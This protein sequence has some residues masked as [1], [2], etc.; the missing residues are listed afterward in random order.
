MGDT[1]N[2]SDNPLRK[3]ALLFETVGW[4]KRLIDLTEEE[5][6]GLIL[7]AQKTEGLEDV[8]TEP[9]LTELFDRLV[10]NTQKPE[11]LLRKLSDI[12]IPF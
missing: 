11:P 9:Y 4:N 1:R 6:V 10:Q 8:Y 12:P 7:I 5:V 3:M 2:E